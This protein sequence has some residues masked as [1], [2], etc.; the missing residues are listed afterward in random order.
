MRE[1][2]KIVGWE[3]K[4]KVEYCMERNMLDYNLVDGIKKIKLEI[5]V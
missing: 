5:L 1:G 2:I 4:S 3:V